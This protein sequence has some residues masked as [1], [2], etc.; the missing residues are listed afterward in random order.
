MPNVIWNNLTNATV[1]WVA[2][3][4]PN[5]QQGPLGPKQT[6]TMP[7]SGVDFAGWMPANFTGLMVV[8]ISQSPAENVVVYA[9]QP[10]LQGEQLINKLKAGKKEPKAKKGLR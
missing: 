6:N 3:S 10:S 1:N 2:I 5:L 4:G 7:L 8:S 9:T